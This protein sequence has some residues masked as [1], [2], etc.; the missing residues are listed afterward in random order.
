MVALRRHSVGLFA[1]HE[2]RP[3]GT[4]VR[5]IPIAVTPWIVTEV[6]E[7]WIGLLHPDLRIESED[8]SAWASTWRLSAGG[9]LFMG[10]L[11][12]DGGLRVTAQMLRGACQRCVVEVLWCAP[13]IRKQGQRPQQCA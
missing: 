8:E 1:T 2:T 3:V 10:F 9:L 12:E 13:D 6:G 5:R 11:A 7:A 4:D